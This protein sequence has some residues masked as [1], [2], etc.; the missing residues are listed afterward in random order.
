MAACDEGYVPYNVFEESGSDSESAGRGG[1]P[2]REAIPQHGRRETEADSDTEMDDFAAATLLATS[3]ASPA[4]GGTEPEDK[5]EDARWKAHESRLQTESQAALDAHDSAFLAQGI[6]RARDGTPAQKTSGSVDARLPV[7][8]Q[9]VAAGSREA[10]PDQVRRMIVEMTTLNFDNWSKE[11]THAATMGQQGSVQQVLASLSQGP[12]SEAESY[13]FSDIDFEKDAL[14]PDWKQLEADGTL[15]TLREAKRRIYAEGSAGK[16]RTAL[17]KVREF[18]VSQARV[19]FIRPRIGDDPDR[20][21]TECL[22]R[23]AFVASVTKDGKCGVDTAEQYLSLYNGWH[24]DT[25]G[26]GLVSSKSLQDE[27]FKRTNQGL[28]RMFPA[29]R[30]DRAAHP[31]ESNAIALRSSLDSLLA[32]YD[33]PSSDVMSKVRRMELELSK[34]SRNGFDLELTEDLVYSALTE[35]MTDGLLRPGEGVPKKGFISQKDVSFERD[36]GGKL[37]AATVMITPIKR[38]GKYVGDKSK[39]PIVIAAHRGGSLRTAELLDI[40]NM[41]APCEPGTEAST[42]AIRFP[43]GKI[44]GLTASKAKSLNNMSM[45]K[46]MKWYYRRCRGLPYNEQVKPHSFR[47]AG[48][49]LLF[50]AGVT[51]EEI[52]T[53][54]RWASDVY[55]IYCRL[56]KERLLELSK[57]MGNVKSTQ[58]LNGVDGFMESMLEADSQNSDLPDEVH[59]SRGPGGMPI[60]GSGEESDDDSDNE[61][62]DDEAWLKELE[63]GAPDNPVEGAGPRTPHA[64]I[65]SLFELDSDDSDA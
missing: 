8:A 47:I 12:L 39:K 13:N 29:K 42:P 3:R 30:T 11:T 28:R 9:W 54:G 7:T 56:S 62:S 64:S 5:S 18:L 17:N 46:V 59:Q 32:I 27:Q 37:I 43:V 25:M 63:K 53:M 49:T 45:G 15:P 4:E 2:S 61:S 65:E 36:E 34:G 38:R 50:A 10:T 55:Q 31:V 40:L 52:K 48:A 26:Y 20:F 57:R 33:E 22:L 60:Y 41:M 24:I 1:V 6:K 51:A 23:Q 16:I 58:F 19:S 44:E 35:L 21:I 14:T